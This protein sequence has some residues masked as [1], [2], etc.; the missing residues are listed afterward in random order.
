VIGFCI[1]AQKSPAARVNQ[2]IKQSA[3]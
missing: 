1:N 2:S 3:N